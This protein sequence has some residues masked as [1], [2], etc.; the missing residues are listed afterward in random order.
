[1]SPTLRLVQAFRAVAVIGAILIAFAQAPFL[2]VHEQD[3]G[4][5]HHV[6][7]QAHFHAQIHST[8]ADHDGATIQ[9]IDPADDERTVDWLHAIASLFVVPY[10]TSERMIL[11]KPSAD[12]GFIRPV[13][14]AHGNSPPC[15]AQLPD[16]SPPSDP[17]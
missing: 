8:D 15:C 16:R 17:A 7:E 11:P 9:E 6:T 2:H 1:M 12:S 13:P 4:A 14:I 5:D 3:L 10:I